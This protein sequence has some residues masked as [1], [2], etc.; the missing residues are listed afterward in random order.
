M[1]EDAAA[2]G[3]EYGFDVQLFDKVAIEELGMESFLSVARGAHNTPPVLIVMRYL[4]GGD[5]PRIGLVG[6]GIVYDSGGY[7]IKTTPGM[8]N[9][10]DDM[11]GA[12]RSN[13]RQ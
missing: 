6:K 2:L 5:S 7:S 10:F 12:R 9:M 11:G 8:K 3:K 4:N 1:A 13:R